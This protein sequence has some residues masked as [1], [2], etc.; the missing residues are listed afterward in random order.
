MR[1]GG[2]E[3]A[4]KVESTPGMCPRFSN[5]ACVCCACVGAVYVIWGKKD[6]PH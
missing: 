1:V 3:D 4:R 2:V 5:S 6:I